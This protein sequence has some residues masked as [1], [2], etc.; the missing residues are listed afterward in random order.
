MAL[1][2]CFRQDSIM[3]CRLNKYILKWQSDV[4]QVAL[5][6]AP[7]QE[8]LRDRAA[9]ICPLYHF[10]IVCCSD[11]EEKG[12]A[13]RMHTHS[14]LPH[15]GTNPS[16]LLT[17]LLLRAQSQGP[18]WPTGEA[19]KYGQHMDIWLAPCCCRLLQQGWPPRWPGTVWVS[20]LETPASQENLPSWANWEGWY[21]TSS[22]WLVQPCHL[23]LFPLYLVL[24]YILSESRDWVTW[25]FFYPW[26]S[27]TLSV[28][29]R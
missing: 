20:V 4:R 19:G 8:P 22:L 2:L 9:S 29:S 26:R 14:Q 3:L 15:T 17:F 10:R 13:W 18:K 25:I 21:A 27:R 16:L 24:D 12:K 11:E 28:L 7:F 1:A 6:G 5:P 23:C